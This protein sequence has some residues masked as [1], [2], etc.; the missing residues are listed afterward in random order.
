MVLYHDCHHSDSKVLQYLHHH[1]SCRCLQMMRH[2]LYNNTLHCSL[3]SLIGQVCC[4]FECVDRGSQ[5]KG[6]LRTQLSGGGLGCVMQ[7]GKPTGTGAK[8]SSA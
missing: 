5:V 2:S 6:L 4:L 3:C 8:G 1:E 7:H